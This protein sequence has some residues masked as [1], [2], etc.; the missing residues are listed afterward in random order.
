MIPGV[1]NLDRGICAANALCESPFPSSCQKGQL[2]SSQTPA[3]ACRLGRPRG[4]PPT[5][6]GGIIPD[7]T[8]APRLW[9]PG[10]NAEED[11][12]DLLPPLLHRLLPPVHIQSACNCPS[13]PPLR[14]LSLL[15]RS[16]VQPRRVTGVPL[17]R[18]SRVHFTDCKQLSSFLASFMFVF[19][20]VTL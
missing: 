20:F 12:P 11:H 13:P 8:G 10:P 7:H 1:P 17:S 18:Y 5:P 15:H 14:L 4:P 3:H 2:P 16:L 6:E 19:L 9:M